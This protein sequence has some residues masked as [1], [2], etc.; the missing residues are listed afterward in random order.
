MTSVEAK[1]KTPMDGK[2]IHQGAISASEDQ[3]QFFSLLSHVQRRDMDDQR[4]V[5][6]P[7]KKTQNVTV[8][9][10]PDMD[11]FFNLVADT[12]RCRLDDQRVSIEVLPGLRLTS[13]SVQDTEVKMVA[14][15]KPNQLGN[16]GPVKVGQGCSPQNLITFGSPTIS[17]KAHSTPASTCQVQPGSVSSKQ[18]TQEST[19]CTPKQ[20]KG[21]LSDLEKQ[22]E[23]FSL[24]SHV[25]R[26]N[27]DDQRCP[28]APKNNIPSVYK[29]KNASHSDSEMDQLFNLVTN[30]Q[31]SRLDDQRVSIETLPGLHISAGSDQNGQV[32]MATGQTANKLNSMQ[33]VIS[34]SMEQDQFFSLLSHVQRGNMDDQRCVLDPNKKILSTSKDKN[35]AHKDSDLEQLLNL[36]ATTQRCRLDDQR[37]SIKKLPG[38]HEAAGTDQDGQKKT[39]AG[40]KPNQ[41]V[42][43]RASS[44]S[45][46]QDQFFSLL[47]HVQRGH[48]DDQRCVL[49]P[50]KQTPS[51]PK[52]K[53]TGETDSDIEQL[54]NLVA[55][56]QRCRLDDQRVS[57]KKLPGLHVAA[58]TDQDGQMKTAAGQ[59][60]NQLVSMRA[61]SDSMEQDQFFSLLS[62]VQS[63][64]MDDQR[65]VLDPNKKIL[66]TSKD[67]NPSH[68]D[69]DIEQLLNL[70]AT[71]QRCRLDDQRVSMKT[72]PGLHVTFSIEQDGHVKMAADQQ[73]D[74]HGNMQGAVSDLMDQEQ[75]F[76]LLN[77]V[78]RGH[79]DDQ[80]CLLN[81][82]K[83]PDTHK[84]K[85][86]SHTDSDMDQLI[87]LVASTQR[88]RLDDQRVSIGIVPG[89]YLTSGNEQ[90]GQVKMVV[91]QKPNQPGNMRG[92]MDDQHCVL[93]PNKKTPSTPKDKNTAHTDSDIEQLLNLVATTQRYRLDDQRVS[94]KKLPGLHVAAGSDQD[95]Q[96]KTAAGQK[97]NQLVKMRA[98]SDSME[99]DQFFS[100]LSHVQSGHMDDQRCVLD[101]NKKILNTSKDKNTGET[102]FDIEQLLNLVATTQRC[103]LDDQ[104]VFMKSLPGL[105]VM[106]NIDQDGHVKLA[107]NQESNQLGN[108]GA[109]SGLVDQDQYSVV[110]HKQR[111]NMDDQCCALIPNKNT[112]HKK[113]SDVV[114]LLN[115]AAS[116]QRCHLENQ[117]VS[118]KTLPGLYVT[119]GNNKNGE[120]NM[121]P[122]KEE[123]RRSSQNL[124][125]AGCPDISIKAHFPPVCF[126]QAG[127]EAA[128]ANHKDRKSQHEDRKDQNDDR[129]Q[130]QQGAV[131][132]SDRDP[133]NKRTPSTG[134]HANASQKD[135]DGEALFNLVAYSQR[136]RLDDQRAS[137]GPALQHRMSSGN[138]EDGQVQMLAGE[139]LNRLVS[140][141]P[142]KDDQRYSS[143]LGMLIGSLHVVS[144]IDHDGRP[145]VEDSQL[146]LSG[147]QG[148]RIEDQQYS[149]HQSP[150]TRTPSTVFGQGN[151][152]KPD[153][154][155]LLS[156]HD[157]HSLQSHGGLRDDGGKEKGKLEE[158]CRKKGK[159]EKE[160]KKRQEKQEKEEK[161]KAEKKVKKEKRDGKKEKREEETRGNEDVGE[162]KEG[163]VG[164]DAEGGGREDERKKGGKRTDRG[165]E[166]GEKGN[167]KKG[168]KGWK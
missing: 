34:D 149:L 88:S 86:T 102:D 157:A 132:E 66:N 41:P 14:G 134:R 56:T 117:N 133:I 161:K 116:T 101:P 71:T 11:Q 47:S 67:K 151:S 126:N 85:N 165:K 68:T 51:T 18:T 4:C 104:H 115:L 6:D 98:I 82:K 109:V 160:E 76:S 90:T 158:G 159:W 123:R 139:K 35:T 140:M 25:Q 87:N 135:S 164:E 32:K 130:A 163:T 36:V 63:G 84:D 28:L 48:M 156:S 138:D 60:S 19:S 152:T 77:H 23:F 38:L 59:K 112:I 137:M 7:N 15:Q 143:A 154:N 105:H 97:S 119:T 166:K 100:L 42:S 103:R 2:A 29:N 52:D 72:L 131:L 94:I 141:D 17:K 91:G 9:S 136:G 118:I 22:E 111:G 30:A 153:E 146:L 49:D 69:S 16:T 5:L 40:Q 20:N 125:T 39:A 127:G 124:L 155:Y 43:T 95:G 129:Q 110:C 145:N 50:N 114:Q 58:G 89:L 167:R 26:K 27:M 99:Q 37:V 46:E 113:D 54:L 45:M 120:F 13:N 122:R 21:A 65:C 147:V 70:V 121:G 168:G 144:G 44:D 31:R 150:R 83:S 81:P 78:Q 92:H 74:Q 96:M 107:A 75:F 61:S 108:M 53:K 73:S 12:Q 106:F 93:D 33:R 148:F 64:H 24:L 62:H 10:D 1:R 142:K 79:L 162:E 128:S 57:I 55:T 8:D 3:D 80:R